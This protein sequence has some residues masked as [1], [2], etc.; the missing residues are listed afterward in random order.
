MIEK[1]KESSFDFRQ[2]V[3]FSFR[4]SSWSRPVDINFT[5][6]EN[7][8]KKTDEDTNSKETIMIR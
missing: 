6:S 4:R 1:K 8:I 5:A 2:K 7:K 3:D